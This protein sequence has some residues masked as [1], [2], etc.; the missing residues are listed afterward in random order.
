MAFSR[1]HLTVSNAMIRERSNSVRITNATKYIETNMELELPPTAMI[2][3]TASWCEPCKTIIKTVDDVVKNLSIPL[4]VIDVDEDEETT[5]LFNVKSMPTVVFVQDNKEVKELRIVGV[6][7]VTIQTNAQTFAT[8]L[9]SRTDTNVEQVDDNVVEL[10]A[11]EDTDGEARTSHP[12]DWLFKCDQDTYFPIKNQLLDDMVEKQFTTAWFPKEVNILPE[13]R[14]EF[15]RM[16]PNEQH[17]LLRVLGF[18][19]TADS[20]VAA[21]LVQNFQN[22]VTNPQVNA[23]Y[24]FQNAMEWV[25]AKVYGQLIVALVEK[26]ND[27]NKLFA[28]ARTEP[29]VKRK[30]D[31]VKK[32]MCEKVPYAQRLVAFAIVEGLFFQGSFCVIFW[33]KE[34]KYQMPGIFMSNEFISR[35]E[36]LHCEFAY[37]MYSLLHDKC[38]VEQVHTIIREA[39]DCEREFMAEALKHDL[40][41]MNIVKME[42]YIKFTAD[43]LCVNLGVPVLYHAG[44]PF[45]YMENLCMQ[46]KTNFFERRVSD[47][48]RAGAET[49]DLDD[50]LDF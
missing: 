24:A 45:R 33:L 41:G 2:K 10:E 31:W 18:F 34:M 7:H 8:M 36:Q 49:L 37:T 35:D 48:Q 9:S 1:S 27:R 23:F 39:V 12:D 32:W 4:V 20:A 47:Y 50:N 46:R 30:N 38:T 40:I 19:A 13:E 42:Q 21:N 3:F 25:H 16:N 15:E 26:Q 5:K 11:I 6:N 17:L 44:L 43:Q 22:D 29:S 28:A 14:K